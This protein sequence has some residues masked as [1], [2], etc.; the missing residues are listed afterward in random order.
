MSVHTPKAK[1]EELLIYDVDNDK[2][3]LKFK[4]SIKCKHFISLYK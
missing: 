4:G 2:G 3:H 1:I